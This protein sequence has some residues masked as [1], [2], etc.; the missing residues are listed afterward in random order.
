MN[1]KIL[2][3][4]LVV[5]CLGSMAYPAWKMIEEKLA[6]DEDYQ[7][8]LD[9]IVKAIE[10]KHWKSK[11]DVISWSLSV[12]IPKELGYEN[13]DENNEIP[14]V[15]FKAR[16]NG[17]DYYNIY[18]MGVD[19]KNVKLIATHDDF[20]SS[21]LPFGYF[22]EPNR[23]PD[24]RYIIST[25]YKN[26]YGCT[27]YD[28][29]L[30]KGNEVTSGRCFVESW[31]DDRKIA[32]INNDGETAQLTLESQ[33]VISFKVLYSYDFDDANNRFFIINKENKAIAKVK[34]N[35]DFLQSVQGDGDQ[36]IYDMPG[37]KNP[38]RGS[39][40]SAECKSGGSFG[41]K[42]TLFTCNYDRQNLVYN[43]YDSNEP[44][45]I[46]GKSLGFRVIKSGAWGMQ[47]GSIYRVIQKEEDTPLTKI[48]YIY[49]AGENYEIK[50]Y[51]DLYLSKSMQEGFEDINLSEY[52]PEL[53][54][55]EKYEDT[56]IKLLYK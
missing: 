4:S 49:D 56:L 37:F 14:R 53:P 20:G 33:E 24:G 43:I 16:K 18:S 3:L 7:K 6:Y 10:L 26:G 52:F 27:L 15:L 47:D 9:L 28:L 12:N 30:R 40:L 8:Q 35:N 23:S 5:I 51:D 55:K 46:L 50:V 42:D 13:W 34:N 41:V 44:E 1:K 21:V 54:S 38:K 29:K 48:N 11:G 17:D 22:T 39:Y 45:K 2:D 32:L 36:I 25:S 19:G 31:D